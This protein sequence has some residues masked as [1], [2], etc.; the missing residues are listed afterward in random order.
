MVAISN[1]VLNCALQ[2]EL[3]VGLK[4]DSK[5]A[6]DLLVISMDDNLCPD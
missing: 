1:L 3:Q 2:R 4:S 5:V 6:V